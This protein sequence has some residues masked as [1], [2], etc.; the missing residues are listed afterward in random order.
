MALPIVGTDGS[1][2]KGMFREGSNVTNTLHINGM[3]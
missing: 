1:K 3:G 2:R